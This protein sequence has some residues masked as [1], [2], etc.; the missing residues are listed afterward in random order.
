VERVEPVNKSA[1]GP[2]AGM[3]PWAAFGG[4][5]APGGGPPAQTNVAPTAGTPYHV[6]LYASVDAP[7]LVAPVARVIA[8]HSGELVDLSISK[9]SLEDVFI[10]LTGRALR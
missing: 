10:H 7:L 3:N 9:P 5:G 2:P 4:G 6:R 8:N 1:A